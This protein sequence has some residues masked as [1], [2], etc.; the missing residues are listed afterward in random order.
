MQPHVSSPGKPPRLRGAAFL[1]LTAKKKKSSSEFLEIRLFPDMPH[2]AAT[3]QLH[4]S[5][6]S[7]AAAPCAAGS[8]QGDKTFPLSVG[9]PSRLALDFRVRG[10]CGRRG[11]V[12]HPS[13][14]ARGHHRC[15][16]KWL[17]EGLAPSSDAAQR[18]HPATATQPMSRVLCSTD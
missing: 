7:S 12:A 15:H 10:G 11:H 5:G 14:P 13:I 16:Q 8:G 17:L 3:E 4:P 9:G 18:D 2:S 6:R 1:F